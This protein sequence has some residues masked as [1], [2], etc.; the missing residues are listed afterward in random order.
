MIRFSYF[1]LTIFLRRIQK[2]R[3][4]VYKY[5]VGK[6]IVHYIIICIL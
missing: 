2:R 6:H 1:L 3:S 4:A 5:Y